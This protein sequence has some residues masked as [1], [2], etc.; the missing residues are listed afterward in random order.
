M[1]STQAKKAAPPQ[2][3][4][5]RYGTRQ[6]FAPVGS[7]A[8]AAGGRFSIELPRVGF[9]SALLLRLAGTMTLS[10]AGA[11]ATRGPFDLLNRLT[12]RVNIGAATIYDTSGYGNY[13]VQRMLTH[14]FDPVTSGDADIYAAPVASGANTW[15]LDYWIPVGENYGR[16][17]D[18]GLINLQAPEI[19]VNVDGLFGTGA[20]IVTNFTS[21]VGTLN[22]GYLYYEVPDPSQVQYPPLVFHR[23]IESR[24][25]VAAI[26]DQIFTAPREGMLM[27]LAHILQLNDAR[28]NAVSRIEARFNKTD[29]VYRYDRA[30][31]KYL[32]QFFYGTPLPVGVYVH[33]WWAAEGYPGE[34][35]NRDMVSSEELSTLESIVTTTAGPAG[36]LNALDS[37]REF[38]QIVAL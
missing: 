29:Q 12:L 20:D 38:A 4:P 23:I 13:I 1:I 37:I 19:Q 24:Q 11:L 33:D 27:R 5:F 16:Q 15:Q 34:G 30:E 3:V 21:F 28:S 25:T 17:F 8:F 10:G 2:R 26:G 7:V 36:T 18:L 14:G 35:D 9:L 22:V 31:L 32:Q 6:R